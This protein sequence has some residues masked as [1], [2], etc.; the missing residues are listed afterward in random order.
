MKKT[1]VYIVVFFL[2]ILAYYGEGFAYTVEFQEG[3]VASMTGSNADLNFGVAHLVY[4]PP[5]AGIGYPQYDTT[6]NR[7]S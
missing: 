3:E 5:T 6:T 7:F 1:I 4:G 2:S